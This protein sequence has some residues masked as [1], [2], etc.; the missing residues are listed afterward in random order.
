MEYLPCKAMFDDMLVVKFQS[1]KA[2]CRAIQPMTSRPIRLVRARNSA[3]NRAMAL[4]ARHC[5]AWP[6]YKIILEEDTFKT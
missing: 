2:I 3:G 6:S 4:L 5:L 1:L